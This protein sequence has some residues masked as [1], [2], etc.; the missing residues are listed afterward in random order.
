MKNNQRFFNL[1]NKAIKPEQSA[2]G[3]AEQKSR[4][5]YSEKRT[6]PRNTANTSEKPRG[7]SR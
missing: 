2:R 1:L 6:R 3:K 5:D 7:K 4:G